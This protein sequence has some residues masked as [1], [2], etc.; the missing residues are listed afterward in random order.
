[1]EKKNSSFRD[2]VGRSIK[3]QIESR[4][5]FGYLNLPKGVEILT[6]EEGTREISLDFLPYIVTDAH[7]PER[8]AQ[9]GDAMPGTEWYR[10]PFRVHR[11]VGVDKD[12]VICLRSVGTKCPV[13]EYREKRQKEGADKEEI[14]ALYAR[15]RS[16]YVVVPLGLKKYEEIPTV[17]D[18]S[19]YLFQDILNDELKTDEENRIFPDLKEGK[20]LTLRLRWKEL[21][22]NVFPEVGSIRFS[23]RQP[24]KDS[25]MNEV[26]SLDELL[27][28]LTYAELEQKFYAM[29]D[30][31]DA[32]KLNETE[33]DNVRK[34]VDAGETRGDVK[35]TR[36][37]RPNESEVKEH[38]REKVTEKEVPQTTRE[39]NTRREIEEPATTK[40][41]QDQGDECIYG[42][43]FGKD[44]EKFEDC[45]DCAKWNA[46]YDKSKKR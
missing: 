45:E 42:H 29:D 46:C 31:Q 35:N 28:V 10:R 22:K 8:D 23:E 44:F 34:R 9:T 14:K 18:M 17:W 5:S 37:E 41:V 43:V 24:F 7:H 27:K 39:R 12:T 32:G 36:R 6:L 30:E 26:P 21:G 40:K 3:R 4:S 16:L 11:E 25:I 1:M 13:C 2:K 15:S 33:T 19:D 38:T 20:T